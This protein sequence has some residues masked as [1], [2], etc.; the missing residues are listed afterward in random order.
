MF[1]YE[2]NQIPKSPRKTTRIRFYFV[3]CCDGMTY[4]SG[5][6]TNLE[7]DILGKEAIEE[8]LLE[9]SAYLGEPE[10]V[11]SFASIVISSTLP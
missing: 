11:L 6:P 9:G 4:N 2:V 5:E 7:K 3:R 1:V 8:A 10:F